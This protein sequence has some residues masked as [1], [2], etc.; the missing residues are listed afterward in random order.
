MGGYIRPL[1]NGNSDGVG[2]LSKRPSGMGGGGVWI[3]SGITQYWT[4]FLLHPFKTHAR[5]DVYICTSV[6]LSFK[7]GAECPDTT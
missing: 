1:W 6:F 3:F 7:P 2:V 5:A 4:P